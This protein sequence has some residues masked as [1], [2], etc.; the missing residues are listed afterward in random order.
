MR[1][2][3]RLLNLLRCP[4]CHGVLCVS[5]TEAMAADVQIVTGD[6]ACLQC[7]VTYPIRKGVPRFVPPTLQTEVSK[8]VDGFGFQH[9]DPVI[10]HTRFT[11]AETFLDFARPVQPTEIVGVRT[12]CVRSALRRECD[13]KGMGG[14]GTDG[15]V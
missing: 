4:N 6:L 3:P 5:Q 1:D 2:D 12:V 8:T 11:D 7:A 9:A 15:G 14:H 13:R 10:Q